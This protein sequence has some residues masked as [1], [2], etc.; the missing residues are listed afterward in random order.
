MNLH[1]TNNATNCDDEFQNYYGA[2]E[3]FPVHPN[4]DDF[5]DL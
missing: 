1:A 3:D 4:D 5:R 2:N